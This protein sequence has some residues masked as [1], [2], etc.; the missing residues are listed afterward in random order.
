MGTIKL[1]YAAQTELLNYQNRWVVCHIY[2]LKTT[3]L[4]L[5]DRPE[6]N[7]PNRD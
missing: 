1:V 4:F 3:I 6:K 2:K 7:H 5:Q